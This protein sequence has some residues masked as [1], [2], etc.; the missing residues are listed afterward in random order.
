MEAV[1]SLW[2]N[3]NFGTRRYTNDVFMVVSVVSPVFGQGTHQLCQDL[4]VTQ[5]TH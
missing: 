1:Q 4:L 3:I 2:K 5:V